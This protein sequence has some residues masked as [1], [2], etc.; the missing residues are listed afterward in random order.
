MKETIFRMEKL[1]FVVCVF[2]LLLFYAFPL[3]LE[4]GDLGICR[5]QR[6]QE[7]HETWFNS[8]RSSGFRRLVYFLWR[9]LSPRFF[10][11]L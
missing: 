1:H 10:R 11:Q 2:T 9:Y 4:F 5:L 3:V 8:R 6:F 7:S